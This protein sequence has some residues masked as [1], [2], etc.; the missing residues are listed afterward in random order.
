MG[1]VGEDSK[2]GR[3]LDFADFTGIEREAPAEDSSAPERF[4][5]LDTNVRD[6]GSPSCS[7]FKLLFL[8]FFSE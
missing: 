2:I 7:A 4:L 5:F 1:F 6:A 8:F 3:F